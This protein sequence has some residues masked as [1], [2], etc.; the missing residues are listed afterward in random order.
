[1][2]RSAVSRDQLKNTCLK[3]WHRLLEEPEI[4]TWV[5]MAAGGCSNEF[6]QALL[7]LIPQWYP[8]Q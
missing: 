2:Q 6:L 5:S 3:S 1:M 7:F 4:R 8:T